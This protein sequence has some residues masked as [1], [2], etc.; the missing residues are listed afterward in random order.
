MDHPDLVRRL[1]ILE[2]LINK[3]NG[4]TAGDLELQ[5]HWAKY[6]C[7]IVAGFLEAALRE[8]YIN[9]TVKSASPQVASFATSTL[10]GIQNPKAQRFIE[11]ARAFKSEWGEDLEKFLEGGSGKDAIDSIMANRHLIAHGGDSGITMARLKQLLGACLPVV[12]FIEDQ[13][14]GRPRHSHNT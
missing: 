10:S 5:A 4:A 12:E 11:T 6:L 8:V 14:A 1:Q 3:A 2:S 9:F 7:V 13:C